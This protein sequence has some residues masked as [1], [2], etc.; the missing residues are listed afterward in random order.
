MSHPLFS[1]SL[2]QTE[3]PSHQTSEKPVSLIGLPYG[4][5]RV[6]LGSVG[7]PLLRQWKVSILVWIVTIPQQQKMVRES[8]LRFLSLYTLSSSPFMQPEPSSW[9]GGAAGSPCLSFLCSMLS[10]DDTR[11][12][13]ATKLGKMASVR[14]LAVLCNSMAYLWRSE[15]NMQKSVFFFQHVG[16]RDWTQAL[17]FDSRHSYSLALVRLKFEN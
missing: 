16:P 2:W 7:A 15:D 1:W 17:M 5:V 11:Q 12:V 10:C 14:G 13:G 4:V 9:L 6:Y 8:L 3:L